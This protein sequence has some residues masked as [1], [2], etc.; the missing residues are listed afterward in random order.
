M[1]NRV[2]V[3]SMQKADYTNKQGGFRNEIVPF[4]GRKGEN[5]VDVAADETILDVTGGDEI[6]RMDAGIIGGPSTRK[7]TIVAADGGALALLASR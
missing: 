5:S 1:L 7:N 6:I 3:S 2:A 4:K